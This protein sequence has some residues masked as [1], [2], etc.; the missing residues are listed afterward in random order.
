MHLDVCV[1]YLMGTIMLS[2]NFLITYSVLV[3]LFRMTIVLNG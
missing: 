3:D 1:I 2:L